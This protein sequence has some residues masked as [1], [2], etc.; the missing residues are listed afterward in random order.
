MIGLLYL[1]GFTMV[2]YSSSL[3][4]ASQRGVNVTDTVNLGAILVAMIVIAIA[5]LF[6]IRTN[7]AKIWKDN[8]EAERENRKIAEAEAREQREL[9]HKAINEKE[10][11]RLILENEIMTIQTKL[12]AE[13]AIERQKHDLKPLADL[14]ERLSGE[15][16]AAIAITMHEE[17]ERII[18][19][20]KK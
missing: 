11:Q 20:L 6:T 10:A 16:R 9:K 13:L 4:L 3:A 2:A 8:Y 17:A 19:E 1:F 14:A 5:G 18:R 15:G 12:E 7:V